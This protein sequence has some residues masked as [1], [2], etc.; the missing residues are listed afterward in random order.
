MKENNSNGWLSVLVQPGLPSKIDKL[1][2]STE[3]W[4]NNACL[5]FSHDGW[6]LYAIGYK[7]AADL[8]VKHIEDYSCSQDILVY[9]IL[10]LYRQYLELAIKDLI[11]QGRKLQDIAE[12]FP[13]THQIDELWKICSKLLSEISP[14]DSTEEQDHIDRL[15]NEF[16]QVDPTSMAFRYPEDRDGNPSLPGI[17]H[18]NLRNVKAVIAKISI[19]LDGA[20]AQ[21][22]EYLSIKADMYSGC[23][24]Y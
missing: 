17:S 1:F 24:D 7:E 23:G 10:F 21:I 20:G 18:I 16:C 13:Q 19:I 6:T 11:R 3:D 12:P 4:W 22:D 8:L 5:N 2:D 14:G 9:P 15:I